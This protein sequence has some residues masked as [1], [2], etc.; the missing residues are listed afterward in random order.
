[1]P[2]RFPFETMQGRP[3]VTP[4][5][6][7]SRSPIRSRT[8]LALPGLKVEWVAVEFENRLSDVQQ[9]NIDLL[10][11]PTSAT[12][13]RRQDVSFSIPIAAE[14]QSG[15]SPCGCSRCIA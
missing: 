9:G 12:L 3:R 6:Y 11:A 1:M 7:A 10:C 2:A 15:G 13:A 14:R 4:S 5:R 8:D